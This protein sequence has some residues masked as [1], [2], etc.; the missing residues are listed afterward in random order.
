MG[1]NEI[2]REAILGL[3]TSVGAI[4]VDDHIVYTSGKHG[5]AY[6]N[7]DAI[8]P[9]TSEISRLCRMIAIEFIDDKIEVVA[10]P[11]IGGVILSQ[12]T[13]YHLSRITGREVLSV[14]A[15]KTKDDGFVIKR[16]YDKIISGKKVLVVED[17]LNTGGSAKKV[18][19]KVR[20]LGGEVVGVGAICNRGGVTASDI[21]NPPKLTS[22]I[23][24]KLDSW[25]EQNC[26]L[27]AK[28]MPI[29]TQIGKGMEY[30]TRKKI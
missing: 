18:V 17:I 7:K 9:H 22:L 24:I 29:N 1:K 20:I 12:W 5:S 23:D 26:P 11:V 13:A 10:A 3:L 27:C 4:I 16:G 30:L 2:L 28:D 19:D 25:D 8:Y 15:E 21:S 14:Y 6:I